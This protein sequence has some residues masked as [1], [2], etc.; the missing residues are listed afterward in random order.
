MFL[1]KRHISQKGEIASLLIIAGLVIMV[2]GIAVGS[3][4]V[5]EGT[6]FLP[7]AKE[8]PVII[9]PIPNICNKNCASDKDCEGEILNTSFIC[10][11]PSENKTAQGV[12]RNRACPSS[13]DPG[14][15]CEIPTP[16][17]SSDRVPTP[18]PTRTPTPTP[19][20][21]PTP[22]PTRTPTPTITP[23]LSITS[24]PTPTLTLTPTP[25][26][27]LSAQLRF[28]VLLPDISE[29]IILI[30]SDP[31]SE[32][33]VQVRV[34]SGLQ[35]IFT[36][37]ASAF[38]RDNADGVFHTDTP[39][40]IPIP[41]ADGIYTVEVKQ[42]L[43]L[44]RRFINVELQQGQTLDCT[45][46][47]PPSSCGDLANFSTKPLFSGD[48]DAYNTTSGSY[49]KIDIADF[50]RYVEARFSNYNV[51][52]SDFNLDGVINTS[53]LGILAKNYGKYGD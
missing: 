6:R 49:N 28:K 48:S 40:S 5:K 29:K 51:S 22:T 7:K 35:E 15:I 18:T 16:T 10:Y 17:S 27:V 23:I 31:L 12:C 44:A 43:S 11:F 14:C 38:R 41:S 39:L 45:S 52:L 24:T 20:R 42:R 13:P 50:Q 32:Q 8:A 2:A 47:F 25:T 9:K 26:P 36:S 3:R 37:T 46:A 4:L 53:D 30:P 1:S 21:T 19:T 33:T 34:L